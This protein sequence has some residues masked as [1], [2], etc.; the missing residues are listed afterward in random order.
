MFVGLTSSSVHDIDVRSDPLILEVFEDLGSEVSSGPFSELCVQ[1]VLESDIKYVDIREYDGMEHLS[2][3][4][5]KYYKDIFFQFLEKHKGDTNVDITDIKQV[6][7]R[8]E[9][10]RKAFNDYKRTKLMY[11]A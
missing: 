6:V 8:K 4:T 9:A 3:D 1:E 2:N 10:E 7:S 11:K 5:E